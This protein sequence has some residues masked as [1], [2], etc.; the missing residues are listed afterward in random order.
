MKRGTLLTLVVLTLAVGGWRWRVSE[1]TQRAA[2]SPLPTAPITQG[3]LI[4]TLPVSGAMESAQESPVRCELDGS[5]VD[6]APD[7]TAVKPGDFAFQ[8]D[9]KD[10]VNQRDDLAAALADA[11]E[12]LST[13]EATVETNIA[14]AQAD[15]E[16]ATQALSLARDNAKAGIEK[17]KA[18]VT[19]AEGQAAEAERELERSQRLAK[20][21]YIA[22]TT[23]RAS[24][25]T[26]RTQQFQ[27]E[28]QRAQL[29]D[30]EKHAAED[31]Q[32]AETALALAEHTLDTAKANAESSRQDGRLTVTDAQ[33][34]LD[35]VEKKIKQCTVTTPV[36]GMMVVQVNEDNWPERRPYRLGDALTS[37]GSPVRV[38]DPTKM[39]VRC[40][41]GEMDILRV[42]QGQRAWV[43]APSQPDRRYR[44]AVALVEELAQS[45]DVWHG[46]SPGKKVF[47]V[48]VTLEETNP[49]YLRPGMTV[50]LEIE[51]GYVR[52]ATMVPIRAVFSEGAQ[53]LVYCARGSS[54]TAVPVTLGARNDLLVEVK[55][56]VKIG[57][58]VALERPPTPPAGRGKVKP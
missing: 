40:Q 48:L 25:K 51:L 57:D 30:T 42:H 16:T 43:T 47:G 29:A 37:G 26:C 3:A 17:A 21:N 27:L 14:Q 18:Q 24:E 31:V 54:F 39:Q 2:H 44:G 41:I 32:T 19:F 8:L 46:G 56:G 20:L 28:L 1:R 6:I 55:G 12:A 5:L 49:A 52:Q 35:Q 38:F 50:D 33:R 23:L 36:G 22:G 9:T 58:R 7:N 10:L 4:V 13:T 45:S 11:E 53:H 34:K 15:A